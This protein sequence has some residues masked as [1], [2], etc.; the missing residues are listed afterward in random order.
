MYS[1]FTLQEA[2]IRAKSQ[3]HL[4]LLPYISKYIDIMKMFVEN[5]I[6]MNS[7]KRK[8]KIIWTMKY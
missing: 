8:K 7:P 2:H 6:L 5:K 3:S 4:S 1:N